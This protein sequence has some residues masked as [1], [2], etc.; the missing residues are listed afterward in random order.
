MRIEMKVLVTG[1]AGYIGSTICSALEENN[2]TPIVIDS[3]VTGQEVFT[4]GR[5]FYRG[6]ISHKELLRQIFQEH[7]EITSA[8]HCAALIVV[9]ESAENP[10]EY[11]TENVSKSVSFFKS[12]LDFGCNQV[13][14]SSSASLYDVVDGF[15]VLES[16]PL[17]PQ[18]PYARTKYMME[19]VLSDFTQAYPLKAIA[20]RYFNPI[21]A[22][23]KMRSGVH[24][25]FP[26]HVVGKL[27]DVAV[28]K[29]PEFQLTGT[30]WPTRD[31]SGIRDYIHVWDLAMAHVKAV[32]KFD[33][34]LSSP[35][36]K[37]PVAPGGFCPETHS[38][39]VINLGTGEGNTVKE[40]IAAFEQVYGKKLPV[41]LA[42]PRLGDVAG[43]FASA[44]RALHLLGWKAQFNLSQGISDALK[45]GTIRKNILGYD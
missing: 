38:Y 1:G 7:P 13:V 33:S 14:F 20:L 3:L 28:G 12:L 2:I 15:R 16:S 25:R 24:A 18:S 32:Q 35:L 40:L 19:M 17:K 9:P 42:P 43:A 23:P 26:S 29:L 21:G 36:S 8:I 30:Q 37:D 45:W 27:V 10:Y 4:K 31:G 34:A 39:R 44:D 6:D 11:Y 5:V 22:D 41:K